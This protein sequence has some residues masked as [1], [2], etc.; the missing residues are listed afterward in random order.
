MQDGFDYLFVGSVFLVWVSMSALL[1]YA[2]GCLFRR[3]RLHVSK[4]LA[5]KK[6]ARGID[7]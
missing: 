4:S 3:V 1:A 2:V 7:N 6:K 5:V